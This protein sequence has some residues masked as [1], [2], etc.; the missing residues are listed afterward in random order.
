MQEL[1]QPANGRE[2]YFT[3]CSQALPP[4]AEVEREWRDMCAEIRA[5]ESLE[6]RSLLTDTWFRRHE[7]RKEDP[8]TSQD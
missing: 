4:V 1:I 3:T 5:Q 6:R 8:C 7:P 2:E